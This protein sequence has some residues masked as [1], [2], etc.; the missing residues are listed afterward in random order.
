MLKDL[1]FDIKSLESGVKI[2]ADS[3]DDYR[4]EYE[5][6]V[7][8]LYQSGYL[9]IKDYDAMLDE[10]ILGFPNEEVKYGFFK[11][12]LYV[13]MPGKNMRGEF[14][15]TNFVQDLWANNVNGFMTRLKA[16]FA[17]IPYD[18]DTKEEKH[19]QKVFYLLFELMGQFVEV[20]PHFAAGRADAV[21]A[22]QDTVYVFEFK[23]TETSTTEKALQQIDE[24]GY[25]IPYTAT[26]KKIVKIGV[27]FS[28]ETRGITDWETKEEEW[29]R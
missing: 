27:E 15:V 10:Y 16:F 23:I 1:D 11:E 22:T 18:L 26:G 13:Y 17:G 2:S 24:K 8:L 6:P 14:R 28:R 21:V 7:P 20:E 4:A 9:T 29:N 19:F 3:I 25:T 12:L 5:D